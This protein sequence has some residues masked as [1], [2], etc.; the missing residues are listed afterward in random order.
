MSSNQCITN[1]CEESWEEE[2][3]PSIKNKNNCSGFVKSVANK[4]NILIPQ[5]QADGIVDFIKNTWTKIDTGL[6]AVRKVKEGYFVLAGLKSSDHSISTNQGHIVIVID[7]PLNHNKYPI[8]WGGSTGRAQSK[9]DKSISEVWNR[10]DRDKVIYY[11]YPKK[12]C[13]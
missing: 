12:I 5:V 10:I 4:L 2:F 3:I 1:K 9:G 13:I 8:C 6:D 11:M 7:G